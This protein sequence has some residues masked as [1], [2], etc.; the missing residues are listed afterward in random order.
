MV[1]A[2]RFAAVLALS[3]AGGGAL[4]AIDAQQAGTRCEAAVET[5]LRDLRGSAFE[6]VDFTA[7]R[8][9]VTALTDEET[10]VKGEGRYRLKSGGG[11][12]PF[13][14]TCSVNPQSGA[15]SGV[16]L[17]EAKAAPEPP[18]KA[19]QP[20]LAKVSPE[21]CQSAVVGVL[22]QRHPR[23]TGIVFDAEARSLEPGENDATA[24]AG[25]GA[26]QRAPGMNAV[27]FRYRCEFEPRRGRVVAAQATE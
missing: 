24:L 18:R 27:T 11:A 10:A 4:A 25:R 13:S 23:V 14:Y 21:D 15:T 7:A 1:H 26:M 16:L 20:D 2:V 5:T 6:S 3:L 12:H 19:W 17:R 8:R 9:S 22:K